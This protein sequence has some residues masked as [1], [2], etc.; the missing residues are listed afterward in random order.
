MQLYCPR[1]NIYSTVSRPEDFNKVS[2]G[3]C[4]NICGELMACGHNCK[5]VCHTLDREHLKI[6]C[7][8]RCERSV[9]WYIILLLYSEFN[10]LAFHLF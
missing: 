5:K 9:I 1:H 10:S 6:P 4:S 3:G 8:Q 2:E 7:R